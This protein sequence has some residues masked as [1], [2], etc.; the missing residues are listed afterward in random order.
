MSANRVDQQP[1]REAS[2]LAA[3]WAA[4]S[5]RDRCAAAPPAR[6]SRRPPN[7]IEQRHRVARRSSGRTIV[8]FTLKAPPANPPAG[9]AITNPPRIALDFLDTANGLGRTTQRAVD[10]P[11]LRSLNVV[12]AGNRT[13]VVFNLNKP[14]IV[15]DAGRR[16]RRR[17]SRWPT[18]ATALGAAAAAD[19]AALRRS[20]ARRRQQ[21]ALRDVDFRRGRNGEGRIIVDLSDSTTGIDIRQQ[22]TAADRRLP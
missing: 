7:S 8:R 15:R 4:R 13:R 12:Q 3:A 10:D 6:R 20:A 14:Q 5:R 18:S 17:W 2:P 21:H 22:G 9:F 11:A 16:Q 1:A 19:G